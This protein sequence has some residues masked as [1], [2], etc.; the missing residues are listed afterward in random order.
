MLTWVPAIGI[1]LP[2]RSWLRYLM[3]FMCTDVEDGMASG[4]IS[5]LQFVCALGSKACFR[6]FLSLQHLCQKQ[7]YPYEHS[8]PLNLLVPQFLHPESGDNNSLSQGLCV[9]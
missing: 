5:K 4:N 7:F 8:R 1:S 2:L 6:S 3:V 9:G